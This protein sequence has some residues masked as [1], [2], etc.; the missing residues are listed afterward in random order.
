MSANETVKISPIEG[1]GR[2][3]IG[4]CRVEWQSLDLSKK[5]LGPINLIPRFSAQHNFCPYDCG[6]NQ[7]SALMRFHTLANA[8]A[9]TIQH[10]DTDVR[11]DQ[12]LWIRHSTM[13][14]ASLV[15]SRRRADE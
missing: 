15:N 4:G 6:G 3:R 13:P 12:E 7:L 14:V 10:V 8:F 11:V 5:C 1:Y 2:I 9:P